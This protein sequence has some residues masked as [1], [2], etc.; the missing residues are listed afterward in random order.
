MESFDMNTAWKLPKQS[1]GKYVSSGNKL[2]SL[3]EK[4]TPPKLV[5]RKI[6]YFDKNTFEFINEVTMDEINKNYL[7]KLFDLKKDDT[8]LLSYSIN[9]RQK[10]Y[11]ERISGLNIA[12]DK[13]DYFMES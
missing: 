9:D 11:L 8:I 13:Y 4:K 5:T 12:L 7:I 10:L 6:R 1:Q 2:L 3:V